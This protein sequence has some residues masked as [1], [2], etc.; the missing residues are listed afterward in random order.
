MGKNDVP[1]QIAVLDRG[2]VFAGNCEFDDEFLVITNA[3]C[4]RYWGTTRGLGELA[5]NGPNPKTRIDS[6]GTVR[7][8]SRALI[9]LIDCDKEEK[10]N[11]S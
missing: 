3:K 8:N 9:A 2:W 7:V 10:W 5:E 1:F 11:A 4:I 6:Y